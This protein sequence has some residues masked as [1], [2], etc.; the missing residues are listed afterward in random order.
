MDLDRISELVRKYTLQNAIMYGG[1]ADVKAVMGKVLAEQPDL[2]PRAKEISAIVA[3][4]VQKINQMSIEA[5][6]K[7]LELIDSSLLKKK[8]KIEKEHPL[9]EL[10]G[11]EKGKVVMR[12]APGPSGPLHIGHTRVA[13][14]ND[15]YVK[16][17]EGT[18]INR[19]EDTNPEKIDPEAYD[20]I[21]EDLE[22]LGVKVH[23]TVIQS[24]R[25]ELYYDI[26]RKLIDM[27]KA[28]VCTCPVEEW[29]KL[30]EYGK[31]CPHRELPKE[32]Q[33][34][35][36]D[37]ML[38]GHYPEEA[39]VL[40]VKTDLNHPNPAIRDFVGLRIVDSVPHPRTGDRYRVYPMMNFSVA[41][42]DHFLGMTHV[43]RGKDHLNN[44]QR[45]EY[46]F[47]YFGWKIPWYHHYG[48]VSVPESIL[49]TSIVARG[50]KAGEYSGWD[51]VRL[52]TVKA[53]KRRGITPEAIRD[54]WLD[55][56]IKDVDIQFSWDTLYAFNKQRIDHLANRYF[57]VW[58]PVLISIE[59]AEEL[60]SHAP[61][62]PNY[63][64]RGMRRLK[65]KGSPI[66]VYLNRND[67][68]SIGSRGRLRL[69]D[70][71]NIEVE[72]NIAI[73]VGNDLSVL[74]EG[75]RI[76]HW[77]PEYGIKTVVE[78]PDGSKKE[79]LSEPIPSSEVG[80]VIQ[81]ERFAFVRIE[82]VTPFIKAVFTHT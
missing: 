30:K 59:G 67:L 81:F 26:A 50:I 42:D 72:G 63:P 34:E 55:C 38:S 82:A 73:Y 9:P 77:V 53:L 18:F 10:P 2:R 64:E 16:R 37:R 22:W 58:D 31:A 49:K 70:L 61:L 29:R 21:P 69:K 71:C 25:M 4:Q 75:I 32:V 44:T 5:Q 20:T 27:G 17:Y 12:F 13:I 14:L 45:Q 24:S 76:V 43:L 41:I 54:Y 6:R 40:V 33:H 65:L 57:F 48:L 79:G 52:G 62:H 47:R 28:Y 66:R 68:E 23:Q 3:E 36:F 60:E 11:A 35:E 56:G 7:E 39:A 78:M 46:I 51:D 15:E 80:N 8:A 19:I 1:K 74:R